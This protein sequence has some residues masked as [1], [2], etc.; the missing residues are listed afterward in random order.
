MLIQLRDENPLGALITI[1]GSRFRVVGVM[2]SKSGV[3]GFDLDDTVCIPP[4]RAMSLFNVDG[5]IEIDVLYEDGSSVE[6]LVEV[7][8]G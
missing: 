6:Q 4:A 2:E 3:L 1:A 7:Q 8:P 5:L